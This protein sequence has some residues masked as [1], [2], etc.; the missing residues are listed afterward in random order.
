MAFFVKGH[1]VKNKRLWRLNNA[2][3]TIKLARYIVSLM[4]STPNS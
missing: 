2:I 3:T 1:V 4:L